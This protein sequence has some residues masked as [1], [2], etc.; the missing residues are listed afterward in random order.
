M[1]IQ[2]I[3]YQ[4]IFKDSMVIQKLLLL[5]HQGAFKNGVVVV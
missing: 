2:F 3:S 1:S 5:S 4:N